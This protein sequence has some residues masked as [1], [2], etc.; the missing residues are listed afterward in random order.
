MKKLFF[1]IV[2]MLVNVGILQAQS[3]VAAGKKNDKDLV[4]VNKK[5]KI[6]TVFIP[7]G[8]FIM[9]SP[10]SEENR[11]L[12]EVQHQVT[13][14]A[15]RMSKYEI[16]NE[17]Y[18]AFLNA[19]RIRGDG[20]C[21]G[22]KNNGRVLIYESYGKY[23]WGLHYRNGRWVVVTGFKKTP[24]TYVTWYGAVEFAAYVGGALPT[25]AQWEYACRAGTTTPFNTGTCLTNEQANYFW[26]VPYG[27]CKNTFTNYPGRPK[28]VG[29]YEANDYGLY[30]MHGN[31][32][33]WCT[34]WY[35][36]YLPSAQTNP[37]GESWG[38]SRVLRGG[39]W[40]INAEY[41][42]SAYRNGGDPNN[43]SIN[44]GFRVVF[45]P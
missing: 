26:R 28:T 39:A 4:V 1:V 27:T 22:G 18:A 7:A 10:E 20:I 5:L 23:D 40:H 12:L 45:L 3:D 34:D 31:V 17:Q 35:S 6:Q 13:L 2:G 29:S 11:S 43:C 37:T 36:S 9:G 38:S 32:W 8:T 44:V 30:D 14:S 15:F 33:E 19:K 25:E 41:C 16:T 24:V 42:R 21:V